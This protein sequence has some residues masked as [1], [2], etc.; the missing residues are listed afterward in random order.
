M[1]LEL[2]L[3]SWL[4][5]LLITSLLMLIA[6][7][8]TI[9]RSRK[10]RHKMEKEL[11]EAKDRFYTNIT[12]EFRTPLTVIQSAAQNIMRH[13]PI[14]SGI[15]DDAVNI[16][17]YSNIVLN[18]INRILDTAR[19]V[20]GSQ[21]DPEW[22]HGDIVSFI[23]MICESYHLYAKEKG[24][25]IKY[26]PREESV[27]MDFVP[28]Y[29]HKVL[30]N[31]IV[32]S[33]KFSRKDSV[34][35]VA[36][37]VNKGTFIISVT[38]HGIG[39]SHE[40]KSNIFKAFYQAKQNST[41]DMGSGIGLP[42]AKLLLDSVGGEI[43][44]F[45]LENEGTTFI[46]KLPLKSGKTSYASV[47]KGEWRE[48][49]MVMP[50]KPIS[51]QDDSSED[52]DAVR[53]LIIEDSA[54]VAR[55]MSTQLNPDYQFFFA[56][57][58]EEGLEKAKDLVPDLIITDILMPGVDGFELCRQIRSSELL[59]HIPII[60]VTAKATHEDMIKG[61]EAGAEAY[62]EKPF[63]SDELNVRVDKLLEQRRVLR[64]K[65]TKDLDNVEIGK[66]PNMAGGDRAFVMRFV[67]A[68][69]ARIK[70]NNV[71]LS[72]LAAD[73]GITRTQLNRKLKAL[74]GMTTTA[75]IMNLRVR[76]AKSLLRSAEDLS[77]N[78]ISYRCGIDDV[79]YFITMFKKATG[80]TPT[81]Y[82]RRHG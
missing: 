49:A 78:E 9:I 15:H 3:S 19:M 18:L 65:Y 24:I 57:D 48:L 66:T 34:I 62:L 35:Q 72:A 36:S 67:E 12:H 81:Q 68:A 32:N 58:G 4:N 7:L 22:M 74:S 45:S 80:M 52:V 79:P 75:Y 53:I 11:Q 43:E 37:E 60:M 76:L 44:A 20:S 2:T 77:I 70:D 55:Y 82:R 17:W 29:M 6:L 25:R 8:F 59:H 41:K 5:I 42:L 28:D 23:T 27:D 61:L 64:E 50:E 14:D 31:L 56:A 73:L 38:D 71:D 33:I 40:Q 16:V 51:L 54:P 46:V 47:A 63:Q 69:M 13:S 1:F 10:R 26:N 30:Q 39:M 21:P